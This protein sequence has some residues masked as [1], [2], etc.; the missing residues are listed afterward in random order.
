MSVLKYIVFVGVFAAISCKPSMNS[1]ASIEVFMNQSSEFS[2]FMYNEQRR[3]YYE[4][5]QEQDSKRDKALEALELKAEQLLETIEIAENSG[6]ANINAILKDYDSLMENLATLVNNEKSFTMSSV[7][8][9][10][11]RDIKTDALVLKILKNSLTMGL[12][13]AFEYK[14]RPTGIACGAYKLDS[15]DTYVSAKKH[16]KVKV[17]LFTTGVQS[18]TMH[19]LLDTLEITSNGKPIETRYSFEQ[20]FLFGNIVLDSLKVGAYK[21]KGHLRLYD[22]DGNF[23]IPFEQQ[24]TVD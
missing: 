3:A 19:P 9:K 23:L 17:A 13:Y 5:I 14:T 24:F 16:S 8:T 6:Q 20:N 2:R 15:L 11:L 10:E 21:I 1:E 12:S 7:T 22:R 4:M 18:N